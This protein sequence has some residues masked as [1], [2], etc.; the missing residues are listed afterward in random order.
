MSLKLMRN[1]LQQNHVF[2]IIFNFFSKTTRQPFIF[3]FDHDVLTT[4]LQVQ[5]DMFLD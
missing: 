5:V 4:N 3:S 2:Q 1:G